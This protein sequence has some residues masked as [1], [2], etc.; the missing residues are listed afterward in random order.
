MSEEEKLTWPATRKELYAH[1]YVRAMHIP[2]RPCRKCGTRIEF[3]RTP[4]NQLMPLEPTQGRDAPLL[5]HF[6]TCPNAKEFRRPE[7]KPRPTQK[8]LF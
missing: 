6:A 2:S 7:Y 1:G 4:D 5:C 8:E 3:W